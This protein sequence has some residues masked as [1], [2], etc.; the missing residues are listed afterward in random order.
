[1]THIIPYNDDLD[2]KKGWIAFD[3]DRTLALY[4]GFEHHTVIGRPIQP[5]VALFKQHLVAGDPVCIFT[6]RV[7]PGGHH[8]EEMVREAYQAI[9]SWC[10][11]NLDGV[12]PIT[13]V[14]QPCIKR[15]YD[16]IAVGVERNTGQLVRD[17]TYVK[18]LE[19]RYE[20]LLKQ[21]EDLQNQNAL[22]RKQAE[23]AER[24]MLEKAPILLAQDAKAHGHAWSD[25]ADLYR[26]KYLE[27]HEKF[28]GR[29]EA[30]QLGSEPEKLT[31]LVPVSASVTCLV[32]ATDEAEACELASG[33]LAEHAEFGKIQAF[34]SNGDPVDLTKSD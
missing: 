18:A 20:L 9:Q 7:S 12:F 8:T 19:A 33:R 14:K 22:L 28:I 34:G 3:L 2:I 32:R 25:A 4:D 30:A 13:S 11:I 31:F 5:M 29:Q 26:R 24:F 27:L 16:D 6:A 10:R 23:E 1:M 17:D 15:L 21:V